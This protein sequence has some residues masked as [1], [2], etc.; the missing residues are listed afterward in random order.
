MTPVEYE[1]KQP[2]GSEQT[3]INR[4]QEIGNYKQVYN[5]T[6]VIQSKSS[7]IV[8]VDSN[9]D[10]NNNDNNNNNKVT[11]TITPA[12]KVTKLVGRTYLQA[13]FPQIKEKVVEFE[14]KGTFQCL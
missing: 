1:L 7:S 2:Q 9:N 12:V 14:D 13:V 10:N 8:S 6:K 5:L 4:I 11:K 3:G